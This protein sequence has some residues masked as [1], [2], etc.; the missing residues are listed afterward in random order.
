MFV[1]ITKRLIN[2]PKLFMGFLFNF[3]PP[4]LGP[5]IRVKRVSADMKQMEVG[6]KLRFWNKSGV[7][8]HYGGSLYSMTDPFY[9][10]MLIYQIGRDHVVWD[11]SAKIHFLKPGRGE[12]TA[13]FVL[14][15][16]KISEIVKKTESGQAIIENFQVDV[17]DSSGNVVA[18]VDKELHIRKK[19]AV[20]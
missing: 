8:T 12:V 5:G 7:G 20:S 1:G 3:W 18:Q 11:K 19:A 17:V 13:K 2:N 16:D 14:T 6:L 10:I 9:M 4:V 15:D